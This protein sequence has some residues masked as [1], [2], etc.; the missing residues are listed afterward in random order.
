MKYFLFIIFLF[1]FFAF[2]CKSPTAPKSNYT[3]PGSRD[4]TWTIDTLYSPNNNLY[5]IYGADTNDIWLGGPGGITSYDR[6]WHYDGKSWTPYPHYLASF[7]NTIF[8]FSKDNIWLGGN[9]GD[10]YHWDGFDW[11]LNYRIS[12]NGDVI[13]IWGISPNDVYALEYQSIYHFDGNSWKDECNVTGTSIQF[14]YILQEG[15]QVYVGGLKSH[16]YDTT[17]DSL[18]FYKYNNMSLIPIY[19]AKKDDIVWADMNLLGNKIYFLIGKD[20]TRYINGQFIKVTSFNISNFGYEFYG[21]SEKDIFIR[22]QDGISHYNGTD[23]QYLLKYKVN[24]TSLSNNALFFD[25]DV[26]FTAK[27]YLYGGNLVIHGRINN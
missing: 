19:S 18:V 8:G 26:F 21:R 22:M 23:I 7:P 14:H 2:N 11:I 6:L 20:L 12:D 24:T 15:N 3:P 9:N 10:I 4:Y 17:K 5:A 13:Y 25:N 16:P 27:D 1:V